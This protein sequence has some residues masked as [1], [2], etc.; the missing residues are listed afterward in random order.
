KLETLADRRL[1]LDALLSD[2]DTISN[3]TRFRA[4]SQEYA[5]ISPVAEGFGQYQKACNDLQSMQEMA[6]G[7]DA[8]LRA[9]ADEELPSA[10]EQCRRLEDELQLLLLPKDPDDDAN[11][12][13]EIRAGTGGDEASL[14]AGDLLRMYLKYAERLGWQTEIISAAESEVGGYKEVIIKVSGRSVYSKLKFESGAHRVQRVP[15]T[16]AQ[17]RIHTSAC[18]VAVL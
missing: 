9:L 15:E 10:R 8:E 3:Q 11:V 1:E 18:T 14:F 16:E 2:A 12:F 7:D 4:L 17:G 5:E 6:S 13:L